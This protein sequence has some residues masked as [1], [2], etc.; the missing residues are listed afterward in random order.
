MPSTGDQYQ[1]I[2]LSK[3][4]A[5]VR[6]FSGFIK[7]RQRIIAQFLQDIGIEFYLFGRRAETVFL[8]LFLFLGPSRKPSLLFNELPEGQPHLCQSIV[9]CLLESLPGPI[10]LLAQAYAKPPPKVVIGAP[11]ILAFH[12]TRHGRYPAINKPEGIRP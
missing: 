12:L 11:V 7:L 10:F 2:F 1:G 8:V 4:R 6:T 5:T 3:I 9:K